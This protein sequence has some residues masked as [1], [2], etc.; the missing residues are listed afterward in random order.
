MKL[1][2][3]AAVAAALSLSMTVQAKQT[4]EAVGTQS[5][6]ST[7]RVTAVVPAI[8]K[9]VTLDG[10]DLTTAAPFVVA[11]DLD[12]G[13]VTTGDLKFMIKSNQVAGGITITLKAPVEM[14]PTSGEAGDSE[15]RIPMVFK[16]GE[17]PLV[18]GNPVKLPASDLFEGTTQV[19]KALTLSATAK[20]AAASRWLSAGTYAAEATLIITPDVGS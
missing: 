19:S 8:F 17:K 1:F 2:K 7:V 4:N 20:D 13:G 6:E 14:L 16:V 5:G 15:K 9:L 12:H 10:A 11:S 3:L 18:A